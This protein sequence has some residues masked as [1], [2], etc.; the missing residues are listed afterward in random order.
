MEE[1]KETVVNP[2]KIKTRKS[3]NHKAEKTNADKDAEFVIGIGNIYR[4]AL[5]LYIDQTANIEVQLNDVISLFF[6]SNINERAALTEHLIVD[7]SF[8]RK[9]NILRRLLKYKKYNDLANRYELIFNDLERIYSTRNKIAH[10]TLDI[11][12]KFIEAKDT[13]R[14]PFRNHSRSFHQPLYIRVDDLFKDSKTLENANSRLITLG[15]QI[16][17]RKLKESKFLSQAAK[18]TSKPLL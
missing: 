14:I 11:T 15:K 2:Q 9:I 7:N 4:A 8:N 18:R 12:E 13:R 1:T 6:F 3:I 16:E 10:G 17:K 5:L